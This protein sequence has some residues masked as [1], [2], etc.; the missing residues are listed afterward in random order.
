MF[1][2]KD[3]F[4]KKQNTSSP[5]VLLMIIIRMLMLFACVFR[6]RLLTVQLNALGMIEVFMEPS[7]IKHIVCLFR[8]IFCLFSCGKV[9]HVAARCRLDFDDEQLMARRCY[10]LHAKD[11]VVRKVIMPQ[12][13]RWHIRRAAKVILVSVF[14]RQLQFLRFLVL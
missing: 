1:Y 14:Q 2:F 6:W 12:F 3:G 8:S 7:K 13:N 11:N 4:L 9:S 5:L 10:L